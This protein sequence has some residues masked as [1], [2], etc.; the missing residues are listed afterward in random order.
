[1]IG[2]KTPVIVF[3]LLV[4]SGSLWNCVRLQGAESF[5]KDEII[6]MTH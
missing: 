3:C 2:S 6:E 4:S 1:M 5:W